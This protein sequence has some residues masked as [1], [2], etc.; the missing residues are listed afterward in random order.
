MADSGARGSKQQ[1]AQLSRYARADAKPSGE[2][3]ETPITA[4]FRE[5]LNVLQYSSPARR[6][7]RFG[8]YRFERP[9][10]PASNRRLVDVSQDVIVAENDCGT[11]EGIFV[12]SII[13]SAKSSSR[14]RR[15]WARGL[16]DQRDFE[17]SLIVAVNQ[18]IT[19]E[20]AGLIQ[21]AGIERVKSARC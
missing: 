5:G 8:R 16:E 9:R 13:E 15:M 17:G 12:E 19:E 4:N 20:L 21:A 3:I 2:I 18:E 10:I 14:W 11:S 1:I 6:A 7:Q